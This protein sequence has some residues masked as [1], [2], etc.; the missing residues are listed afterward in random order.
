M[1]FC[2]QEDAM[3]DLTVPAPA[4]SASADLGIASAAET[5]RALARRHGIVHEPTPLDAFAADVSRLSD[6]EAPQ[7]EVADLVVALKRAGVLDSRQAAGLYGDHLA[8]TRG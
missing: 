6:A 5:I 1:A 7:D 2:S 3:D 8:Q 4:T